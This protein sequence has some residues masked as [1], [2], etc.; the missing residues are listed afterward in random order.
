LREVF[1]F[2]QYSADKE[3][4]EYFLKQN[5]KRFKMLTKDTRDFLTYTTGIKN[6]PEVQNKE[7]STCLIGVTYRVNILAVQL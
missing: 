3:K 1:G 2:I 6:L 7:V 4:L 5:E